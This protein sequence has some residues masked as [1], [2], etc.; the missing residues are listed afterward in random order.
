MEEDQEPEHVETTAFGVVSIRQSFYTIHP[1]RGGGSRGATVHPVELVGPH[2][3]INSARRAEK[4]NDIKPSD[5]GCLTQGRRSTGVIHGY[6][7]D[8]RK[9]QSSTGEVTENSLILIPGRYAVDKQVN[10]DLSPAPR[11]LREKGGLSFLLAILSIS[12]RGDVEIRLDCYLGGLAY[13]PVWLWS[14]SIERNSRCAGLLA[15]EGKSET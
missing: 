2:N 5:K 11:L 10:G 4:L 3:H 6:T 8:E 1:K 14:W 15:R 9:R 12:A 7:P 13:A